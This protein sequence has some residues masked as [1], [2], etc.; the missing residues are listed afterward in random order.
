MMPEIPDRWNKIKLY[1]SSIPHL[2]HWDLAYLWI[3]GKDPAYQ[4]AS[5]SIPIDAWRRLL[6]L[7]LAGRLEIQ[8][9][10]IPL[11]MRDFTEPFG[12]RKL[13][14]L[15][16]RKGS[17]LLTVGVISPVVVVRPLPDHQIALPEF[18][19]DRGQIREVLSHLID[20]LG[21]LVEGLPVDEQ[22]VNRPIQSDLLEL[23]IRERNALPDGG[24]AH[25]ALR[26]VSCNILR[27]IRFHRGMEADQSALD[28]LEVQIINRDGPVERQYVPRCQDCR[29]LLTRLPME[30]P[31]SVTGDHVT[32]SCIHEHLTQIPL[33]NLFIWHRSRSKDLPDHV[34]WQDRRGDFTAPKPEPAWPPVP[35]V[36]LDNPQEITFKWNPGSLG[37]ESKRTTLRLRFEDG[38][39]RFHRLAREIFYDSLLVP[40]DDPLHFSGLPVRYEWRD[41]WKGYDKV[42][43]A[44]S[45]IDFAGVK[46]AGIPFR[47]TR[48]YSV[49]LHREPL[50]AVG[51]YP[52]P[53]HSKW[54]AYRALALG[55]ASHGFTL[56]A[57]GEQVLSQAVD[58]YGWPDWIGLESSSD[59][60]IG[61]SFQ[62]GA[63]APSTAAGAVA[64]IRIGVDFGTSNTVVYYRT[65]G[66][67]SLGTGSHCVD[68]THFRSLI[69]WL[70]DRPSSGLDLGWFAP[71][72]PELGQDPHLIPSAL[73]VPR[74]GLPVIRWS[75]Q[76][77]GDCETSHAFK[78]DD[79]LQSKHAQRLRYLREVFFHSIPAILDSAGN[80][81]A[82]ASLEI[83]FTYPLAFSHD[84]RGKHRSM[85][86]E[87]AKY[88]EALSGH[89]VE[90]LS[91]N[92]S[93]AAVR[94]L[95]DPNVGSLYLVADL[96]GRTLDV[97]LFRPQGDDTFEVL[98]IGS[99]DLGG[100]AFLNSVV[101]RR[102]G[103]E[104][105]PIAQKTYWEL[106]NKVQNGT[107]GIAYGSDVTVGEV[108]D[109]L[110]LL[111]FEYLRTMVET[112]RRQTHSDGEVPVIRLLLIGNGW[113]LRDIRARGQD[114]H[115]HFSDF[116]AR[117][118][119]KMGVPALENSG[120]VRPGVSFSKH[121]VA[122][123]ALKAAEQKSRELDGGVQY[124]T[125][126]P[127]GRGITLEG[128]QRHWHE[129]SGED[130]LTLR[131]TTL[132]K[133]SK[134]DFDLTNRP[135]P[136]SDWDMTLQ[137]LNLQHGWD[138]SEDQLRE[139]VKA[140]LVDDR[141]LKGPLQL[142]LEN[143]W[144][145]SL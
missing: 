60:K 91:V 105:G 37:G 48:S 110:H 50:L 7:F 26:Q 96:G 95:G 88:L 61:V 25:Y 19:E 124:R 20:S 23:L 31:V 28:P 128:K 56:R 16:L 52:A 123:G 4:P 87:I 77:P 62:V 130:G 122:I 9:D 27:S 145:L 118:V 34:I 141:L 101:K 80:R 82:L 14:R 2:L 41:G 93:L 126:L 47:F 6:W 53:M 143:H 46:I 104:R 45:Q 69:H 138:P 70:H 98:Q 137:Q 72:L 21:L 8:E 117:T 12:L 30:A 79:R 44:T 100:E 5:W 22:K 57:K 40:L 142:I 127:F 84:Q 24:S 97:S 65:Q 15:T 86:L 111:A 78:W 107:A 132:A 136:S 35:S 121:L 29:A 133:T 131:G 10:D 17:D 74:E 68:P 108:M 66:D 59:P 94:A 76:P 119:E 102:T 58:S 99:L 112:F 43:L 144:S 103:V 113:R 116:A 63:L 115:R 54:K 85:M 81:K 92:E 42:N 51:V 67:Q 33:E 36:S 75:E 134:I 120:T 109:R 71:T 140:C 89:S 38:P 55:P 83:G 11:P 39:P 129:Y 90:L 125:R 114:P 3:L 64:P 13:Q 18:V 73:W 135:V 106:R 1:P 32:L 49:K 139:W